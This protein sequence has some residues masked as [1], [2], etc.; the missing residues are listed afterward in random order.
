[1]DGRVGEDKKRRKLAAKLFKSIAGGGGFGEMDAYMP[2][3]KA[4]KI[5]PLIEVPF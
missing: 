5:G 4:R 2:P 3:R 1:M